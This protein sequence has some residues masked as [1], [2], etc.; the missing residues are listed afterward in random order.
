VGGVLLKGVVGGVLWRGVVEGCC[1]RVLWKGVV[2]GVWG[3][4]QHGEVSGD[5][6]RGCRGSAKRGANTRRRAQGAARRRHDTRA[7][8]GA[9]GRSGG[10]GESGCGDGRGGG[11]R[12]THK[13]AAQSLDASRSGRDAPC[14]HMTVSEASAHSFTSCAPHAP[15]TATQ[16]TP[17]ANE[18]THRG[19]GQQ[20]ASAYEPKRALKCERVRQVNVNVNVN[21]LRL[22][23]SNTTRNP[24]G[25]QSHNNRKS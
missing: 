7:G 4:K 22:G 18:R 14:A 19:Q 1:G 2:G 24:E 25:I 21:E 23:F 5:M 3:G 9:N 8:E 15:A 10:G 17:L 16:C 13:K 11:T 12:R 20:R 6:G